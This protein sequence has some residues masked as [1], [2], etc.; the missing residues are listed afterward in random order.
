MFLSR[1]NMYK[2]KEV[3]QDAPL[4]LS[5]PN[6]G[7]SLKENIK[8]TA[9]A[10]TMPGM[11]G[12]FP[13]FPHPLLLNLAST[14]SFDWTPYLLA[15]QQQEALRRQREAEMNDPT[16]LLL[17]LS[18]LQSM[19]NPMTAPL[20][21]SPEKPEK[22]HED[23][24][25]SEEDYKMVIKNGVLMKKQKQ[26]RYRT[27][28]PH[29][30]EHCNARFTLRSNMDRHIKQQHSNEAKTE[31]NEDQELIIDDHDDEPEDMEEEG[32]LFFTFNTP[33]YPL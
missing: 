3:K 30:C 18:K 29:E 6:T 13:G 7:D 11:L 4:D 21:T 16:A 1:S 5:R 32:K 9:P 25:S 17:H 22:V 33:F 10:P 27:E 19:Q 12:G 31:S 2:P 24:K 15:Y 8:E 20:A 26:R 28:R 23:S 14:G